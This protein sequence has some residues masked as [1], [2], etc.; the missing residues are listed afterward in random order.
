MFIV[1]LEKIGMSL[2]QKTS[3]WVKACEKTSVLQTKPVKPTE[4][5]GL[6][7]A[8]EQ[9]T[10]TFVKKVES[11]R[12]S[13]D[14]VR[15]Y[16]AEGKTMVKGHHNFHGGNDFYNE[17]L[18]SHLK[19]IEH[20]KDKNPREYKEFYDKIVAF[21]NE[22]TKWL[23]KDNEAF[24]KLTPQPRDCVAYRGVIRRIGEARQDFN[25]I[26][27]AKAGDT[28]VPTRGFAYGAHGKF[29]TYQYLGSPQDYKGNIAFEPML[30]EYRIPKGAQI[31]SN[32]EH[33]GEVVFPAMSKFK[34]ISKGQREIEQLE[35]G[36]G[37]VI[38]SYPYKHV[39]LE[40]I[41][42]IPLLT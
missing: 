40:Y 15:P 12:D 38:G 19:D 35:F 11:W 23:L 31:S 18:E 1:G 26:N 9:N 30:I 10:D 5:K 6:K 21:Y 3:A 22:Q 41:P 27:S 33:G 25:V 16:C 37:N 24:T 28:I 39:V 34:L 17:T 8:P 42:D 20:L 7:F 14:H 29:G 13:E 36:T 2:A 4:L 32:M